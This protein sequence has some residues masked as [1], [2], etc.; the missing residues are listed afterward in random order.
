MTE[1]RATGL[2]WTCPHRKCKGVLRVISSS[3][4]LDA[5]VRHDFFFMCHIQLV[6]K[7]FVHFFDGPGIYPVPSVFGGSTLVT[8][9]F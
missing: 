1:P 5:Q 8:H 3:I 2:T 6:I 9:H 4:S 7:P